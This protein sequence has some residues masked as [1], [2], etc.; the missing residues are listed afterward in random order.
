[1]F[2]AHSSSGRISPPLGE[3]YGFD[4]RMRYLTAKIRNRLRKFY[5]KRR[6]LPGYTQNERQVYPKKE[7]RDGYNHRWPLPHVCL[8]GIVG[9]EA[10][11]VGYD[12][13]TDVLRDILPR[14]REYGI[15]KEQLDAATYVARL[16]EEIR[17]LHTL[18]PLFFLTGAW[19]QRR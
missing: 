12:F 16:R 4:S 3:E 1:M 11:W 18:F 17:Q 15:V 10:E 9:T 8:D 6:L 2:K 19:T 7:E 5:D 14:L 13:L